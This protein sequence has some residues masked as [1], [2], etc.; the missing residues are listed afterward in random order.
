MQTDAVGSVEILSII[1][2]DLFI[3]CQCSI[4][5]SFFLSKQKVFCFFFTF[6]LHMRIYYRAALVNLKSMTYQI[7]QFHHK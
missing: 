1:S 2:Q 3:N 6:P 7:Q 4:L 5:V